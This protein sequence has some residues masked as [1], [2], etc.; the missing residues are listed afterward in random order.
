MVTYIWRDP[1]INEPQLDATA[2]EPQN[3][4]DNKVV[5]SLKN[6]L[7][8]KDIDSADWYLK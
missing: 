8:L 4:A 2:I 5:S 7:V 1:T 6:Q 3:Y